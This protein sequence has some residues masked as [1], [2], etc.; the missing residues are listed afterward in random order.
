MKSRSIQ[1]LV[2][3]LGRTDSTAGI[4]YLGVAISADGLQWLVGTLLRKG[5]NIHTMKSGHSSCAKH[6]PLAIVL[7]DR[8]TL[9]VG[10][11]YCF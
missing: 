6:G 5:K 9:T 1:Y 8:S 7:T 11:H 3:N 2:G 4:A 10:V